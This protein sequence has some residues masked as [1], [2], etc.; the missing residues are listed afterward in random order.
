MKKLL[1]IHFLF[2]LTLLY[3]Q[4]NMYWDGVKWID[5]DTA[6]ESIFDK[7]ERITLYKRTLD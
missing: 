3:G 2:S 5:K 1:F 6:A 4:N 7:G